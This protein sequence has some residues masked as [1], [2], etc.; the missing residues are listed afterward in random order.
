MKRLWTVPVG[1]IGAS[2]VLAPFV[3]RAEEQAAAGQTDAALTPEEQARRAAPVAVV[4]GAKITV[5]EF[6]EPAEQPGSFPPRP[7]R[8]TEKR[9]EFLDELVDWSSRPRRLGGA[10]CRR[11]REFASR[12]SESCPPSCCGGG[13]RSASS[14]G[15]DRGGDAGVFRREPVD[16]PAAREGEGLSHPRGGSRK[17]AE[18]ARQIVRDNVDTREFRELARENS[19]DR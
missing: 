19:E 11:T 6:E 16:L 1:I 12:S 10:R 2:V 7:I 3:I 13:R 5:G 8:C 4:N 17:G 18:P 15:R 9:R 14:R